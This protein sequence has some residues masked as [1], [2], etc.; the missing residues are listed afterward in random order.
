MFSINSFE[1]NNIIAIEPIFR[2]LV[3]AYVEFYNLSSDKKYGNYMECAYHAQWIKVLKEAQNNDNP[4]LKAMGD[5]EETIKSLD[6]H[7]AELD[8]LK[9][10]GYSPLNIFRRFELAG[11]ENEYRSVYNFLSNESHSNIRALISRHFEIDIKHKTFNV[12]F[13]KNWT[14]E[15][16]SHYIIDSAN[17]L[18]KAGEQLHEILKTGLTDI[19]HPLYKEL[20]TINSHSE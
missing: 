15:E 8:K 5:N 17:Y 6:E 7:E 1:H 19:F 9:K 3:E 10:D 16:Y 2:S 12:V 18:L 11:M 4:Y 20:E 14:L 13:Y